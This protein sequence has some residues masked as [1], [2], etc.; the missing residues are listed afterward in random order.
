[1]AGNGFKVS[2]D[3]SGILSLAEDAVKSM[4]PLLGQAVAM[5]AD[6]GAMSWRDAVLKANLSIDKKQP[7]IESIQWKMTGPFAA[8]IWSDYKLADEIENGRLSRDLKTMLQTSTKTRRFKN[9]TKYLIIPFR[10]NTPGN[11]AHAPAMPK[12]I[13]AAAKQLSISSALTPGSKKP[14]QRL[15]PSGHIV[16]QHSYDWGGRL[17]AGLSPKLKEHHKTD[18][19]AGMVRMNT[20]SGNGKSSAYLTFRTM[21]SKSS[22]WIVPAK[23]GLRIVEKVSN[24]LQPILDKGIAEAI[25]R[26]MSS[27]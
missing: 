24:D 26:G 20:S 8:E 16:P 10:H 27:K 4:F 5:T 3:L 22:G 15:S 25:R 19:H 21:S 12:S 17:P 23:P 9:G 11:T 14:A 6:E 1:M 13:Y 2:V 18:I 7:Y